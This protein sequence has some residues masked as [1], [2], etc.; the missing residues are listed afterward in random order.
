M[1]GLSKDMWPIIQSMLVGFDLHRVTATYESSVMLQVGNSNAWLPITPW[2][3][4][5]GVLTFILL[6]VIL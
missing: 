4:R 6:R 5:Q 2:N 3:C 1:P